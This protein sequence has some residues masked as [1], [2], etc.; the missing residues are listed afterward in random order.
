MH[1]YTRFTSRVANFAI[2]FALVLLIVEETGLA[3]MSSL[4]VIALVVPSA[5]T[6]IVAGVAADA[7]PKRLLIFVFD[8]LKAAVCFGFVIVGADVAVYLLVAFLLASFG[9]FAGSGEA[10]ILPAI[11]PR[12]SLVRANAIGQAVAT[13]AQIVGFGV[14]TP[15]FIRLFDSP[16]AL[17]I[18]CGALFAAA[19][20]QGVLIGRIPRTPRGDVGGMASGF[21]F[22]AGWREIQRQPAVRRAVIQLTLISMTLLILS[23]I[24]PVYL[25]EVLGLPLEVG[26]IVLAPAALGMAL[27]LRIAGFLAGFVPSVVLSSVGFT[28]FIALLGLLAFVNEEATFLSGYGV[29]GWLDHVQIRGFDAGAALAMLIVAPLGFSYAVVQVAATSILNELVP[30]HL[31]GRVLSTQG[32]LAAIASSLPVLAAGGLADL[33]GPQPV[34]LLVAVLIAVAAVRTL[35]TR[36]P[37]RRGLAPLPR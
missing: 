9:Q 33:I 28:G 20:W 8:L 17:F 2:N 29:F 15:V 10:A 21:W 11:V 13:L 18:F 37:A 22:L 6:G 23:G 35:R 4:L 26:V 14:V 19:A 5:V 25:S 7:L 16:N 1:T 34:M 24:I 32:A 36:E 30:L 3:F 31:Q 12:E 27:G